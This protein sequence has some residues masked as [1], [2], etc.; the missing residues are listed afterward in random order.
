MSKRSSSASI[1]HPVIP[2][3]VSTLKAGE[4]KLHIL[5][6][7]A[8]FSNEAVLVDMVRSLADNDS[9][10]HTINHPVIKPWTL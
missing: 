3:K 6:A 10:F 8:T 2:D 1:S 7:R 5:D 9:G 4:W